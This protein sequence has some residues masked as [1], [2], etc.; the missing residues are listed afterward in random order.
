LV[1]IPQ[2]YSCLIYSMPWWDRCR[3]GKPLQRRWVLASVWP[4]PAGSPTRSAPT[5]S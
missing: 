1:L 3:G 5:R 2:V 4:A